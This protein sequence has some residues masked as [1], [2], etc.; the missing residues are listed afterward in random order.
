VDFIDFWIKVPLRTRFGRKY[1]ADVVLREY[2]SKFGLDQIPYLRKG[3]ST[4]KKI[5]DGITDIRWSRFTILEILQSIQQYSHLFGVGNSLSKKISLPMRIITNPALPL[6][7]QTLQ[8][9]LPP[10]NYT[11]IL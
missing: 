11:S 7:C 4:S 9:V 6:V 2:F 8:A 3:K 10:F 1:Y 5:L